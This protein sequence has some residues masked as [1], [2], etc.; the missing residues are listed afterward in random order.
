[1]KVVGFYRVTGFDHR[2][3]CV[4]AE[5]DEHG[6][7][8]TVWQDGCRV[9]SGWLLAPDEILPLSEAG[10]EPGGSMGRSEADEVTACLQSSGLNRTD[11]VDC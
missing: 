3:R 11:V 9:F 2:I 6:R 8:F 5:R 7:R 10:H 1:M 4:T